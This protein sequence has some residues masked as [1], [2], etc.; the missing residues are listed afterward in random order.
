MK[1]SEAIVDFLI[2]Q[3]VRGNSTATFKF[4]EICLTN[5]QKFMNDCELEEINLTR[6]KMY[7]LHLAEGNMNSVSVQTYIR[8]LRA[9]LKYLYDNEFIELDI[10]ARFRLP[11]CTRNVIDVL[12][13]EEVGR[14]FDVLSG[15]EL[16]SLRN[17]LIISLMLDSG[18]RRHEVV[19]LTLG[20]VH[21]EDNYLIVS[22]KGA[23]QRFVPFGAATAATLKE[24]IEKVFQ[25]RKKIDFRTSLIIKVSD[26]GDFEGITDTTLKQLF[27]A[28][29]KR[30]GIKRLK[31]HLLRHTFATRYLENGGNI[32]ALQ[33]ILG[34]TSLE[35]VKKYLH[36]ANNRIR[37]DF[38]KFSP[39]DNIKKAKPQ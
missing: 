3:R 27:R 21:L 13:D 32:Y 26:L 18:L 23:K 24:Y 8:G 9:F 2:E 37:A 35:M 38:P 15:E 22:G 14:V 12:S 33:A 10:C 6:C 34:H 17:R 19:L 4:Y 30:T 36:L 39:L 1:I 29:K 11:K 31:A 5:F 20:D 16:L 28:L 7:Y 25:N